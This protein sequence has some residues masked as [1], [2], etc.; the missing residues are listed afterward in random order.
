MQGYARLGYA[1]QGKGMPGNA[2]QCSKN[3]RQGQGSLG[4]A[5]QVKARLDNASKG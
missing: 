1:R 2:I 4:K 5:K 3:A